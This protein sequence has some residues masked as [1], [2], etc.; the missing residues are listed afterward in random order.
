MA[1]RGHVGWSGKASEISKAS[2]EHTRTLRHLIP[3]KTHSNSR[4]EKEEEITR[5]KGEKTTPAAGGAVA[6]GGERR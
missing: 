4:G 3:S 1:A 6:G 5:R 2:N